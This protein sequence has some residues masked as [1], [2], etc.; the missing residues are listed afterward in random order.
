MINDE[1]DPFITAYRDSLERQR[2]LSSQA[3]DNTRK[4][5]FQQIMTSANKVGMLYS[6]LPERAKTQYDTGTY[7]PAVASNQSTYQT[8]L[9][10]LR[11]N[12]VSLVNQL[13]EINEAI[14]NL[15]STS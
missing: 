15:N 4:N 3:I 9:D 12:T 13:R 8:G 2:D 11:S 6:N 5:Q 14:A 10:K 1:I 7:L